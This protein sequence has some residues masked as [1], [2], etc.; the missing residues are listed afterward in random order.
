MIEI[1]DRYPVVYIPMFGDEARAL[2]AEMSYERIADSIV[3]RIALGKLTQPVWLTGA[4][5]IVSSILK[6]KGVEAK[7]LRRTFILSSGQ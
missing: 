5:G 7:E 6:R 4:T 3:D 2:G 1:D